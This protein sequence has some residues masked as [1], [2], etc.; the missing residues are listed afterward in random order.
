MRLCPSSHDR[1]L[2]PPHSR[3]GVCQEGSTAPGAEP[4]GTGRPGASYPL[5]PPSSCGVPVAAPSRSMV[6]GTSSSEKLPGPGPM[7]LQAERCMTP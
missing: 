6:P 7:E 1:F 3:S 5:P 4:A 2:P